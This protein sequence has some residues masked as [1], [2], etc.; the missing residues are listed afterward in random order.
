MKSKL[1]F[2]AAFAIFLNNSEAA[3]TVDNVVGNFVAASGSTTTQTLSNFSVGSGANRLLTVFVAGEGLT[4]VTSVTYGGVGLTQAAFATTNAAT[5][6]VD[7]ASIWYLLNPASGTGNIVAN[8]TNSGSGWHLS[9]ASF[10]D[11]AQQAP[12]SQTNFDNATGSGNT[13]VTFTQALGDGLIVDVFDRNNDQATV[14]AGA[15]Q[16][17]IF[18]DGESNNGGYTV[19][20]SYQIGNFAANESASWSTSGNSEWAQSAA[21]FAAAVPEPS[22]ALLGALGALVLLRRRR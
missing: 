8:T 21:F 13:N 15:G 12:S 18:A 16:T 11:V 4:S 19:A 22:T 17:P 20:A 10:A 7:A 5:G 14:T 2:T 9:A 6:S 3:V 1:V